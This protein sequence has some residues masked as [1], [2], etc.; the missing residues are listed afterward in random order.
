MRGR[1]GFIIFSF[2][3][4]ML[5][6]SALFAQGILA[7]AGT[8]PSTLEPLQKSNAYRQFASR[9]YS[10]LS[11]LLYL[12]DRFG[13]T[14]YEILYD[15]H[16]YSTRFAKQLARWFL[17]NHYNKQKT[18][19]WIMEWC[20]KSIGGNLIWVKYPE[21][22]LRLAREVLFEELKELEKMYE[23]LR[24]AQ[25]E[26]LAKNNIVLAVPPPIT[27]E[28]DPKPEVKKT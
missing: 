9:P 1:S 14:N 19:K 4:L 13:D 8:G 17:I 20:N 27:P 22:S 28:K 24:E 16:Y 11:K 25:K 5:A 3:F 23:K 15:G 6:D 26:V 21:G 12:I 18:E 2:V 10:E 7:V